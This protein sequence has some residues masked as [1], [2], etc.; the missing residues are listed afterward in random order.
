MTTRNYLLRSLKYFIVC[1]LLFVVIEGCDQLIT[2]NVL[3]FEW[4][5]ALYPSRLVLPAILALVLAYLLPIKTIYQKIR[6]DKQKFM[7]KA[8]SSFAKLD[9]ELTGETDNN[10]TF[11]AKDPIKR[12]MYWRE[13]DMHMQVRGDKLEITGLS[14][15]V[16]RIQKTLSQK[17]QKRQVSELVS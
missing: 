14:T 8:K 10:L 17:E 13:D 6:G 4:F 5:M 7:K 11:R 9:Y 16:E 15:D 1:H 2:Y 12:F 3:S